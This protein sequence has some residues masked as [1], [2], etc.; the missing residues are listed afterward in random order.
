MLEH[1]VCQM[2]TERGLDRAA[3][4]ADMRFNFIE[5]VC[6]ETVVKPK[7]SREHVRSTKID[8]VLTGKYTALPCFA[9]IMAAVFFLTFHVIGASL[10][11]VLEV[12]IGKL[13]ELVDSAMTAWGVNPVLHSLVI[14]GIFNGVGSVL[15]FL[16]IIVTLFFFL[17]ILEDSGYMARVAFIMDKLLRKLGLSGRSIVPMLVG[18]GCTVPGVMASRT[19]PSERDRKMTILLTPFMSC[20]AKL[21]IYAFFT[22]AFFPKYSAL[23]MVLLYFGG[24]FMAVLMAMLMQGTLFQ[25]EAVPFVMELPNYRSFCGI[26]QKTSCNGHSPSFLLPRL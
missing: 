23:V 20:S 11:S 5:K 19:L 8:R 3:A 21:P 1:I 17:S 2:E 15:S 12:L 16:P 24:I 6:R 18:F 7:E 9:G 4:I 13:T 22:A 10:Q 25:G 14:D 26:R